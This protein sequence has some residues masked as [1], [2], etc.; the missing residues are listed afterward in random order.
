MLKSQ[1]PA[2]CIHRPTGQSYATVRREGKRTPVYFGRW[3]TPESLTLYERTLKDAG[4]PP[5][6]VMEAVEK[7]KA[8]CAAVTSQ[9]LPPVANHNACTVRNLWAAFRRWAEE[10]YRLPTGERSR[11]VNNFDD[12][13]RELLALYGDKR[14]SEF[15][16]ADLEAVRQAMI[17]RRLSRG[18]VNK[19]V[20]KILRIFVWGTDDGRELAPVA[21]AATLKLIRRLEAHRSPAKDYAPVVG[22]DPKLV[23]RAADAANEVIAAMVKLQLLTGMRPGEVCGLRKQMVKQIE[24]QWVADYG[25]EHK[26]AY[27]K[28]SRIVSLGPKSMTLLKDWL[29]K[30]PSEE[31]Y[32]FRPTDQ[33]GSR[34]KLKRFTRYGYRESIRWACRKAGIPHIAPNRIRHTAAEEIRKKYGLEA[35]QAVLGHKSRVSSERY[36]PTVKELASV[37]AKRRG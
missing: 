12:A 23:L 17:D 30:C 36:A 31:S 37:V 33:K 18:V 10:Y 21:V 9:P 11:E 25:I 5:E 14:T 7:A 20:N 19:R 2:Y 1:C 27:R 28:Q 4:Y 13:V 32:V 34:G 22:V 35:V 26:M 8:G 6:E 16:K 29:A 15:S 3:G 24:G